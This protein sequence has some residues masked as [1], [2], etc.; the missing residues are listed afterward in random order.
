MNFGIV[1]NTEKDG[2]WPAVADL[3]ALLAREGHSA[4]VSESIAAGFAARGLPPPTAAARPAEGADVLLSFGGDGSLLRAAH[5]AGAT[6]LLGVNIGRLG[7]LTKAEVSDLPEV[8]AQL[9]DG[10]AGTE[11][12]LTLAVDMAGATPDVPAWALNDVVVDKSGTT[13]MIQ[14]ETHIDGRFLNTYW[15]DGLIAATPTGS[16]AYSLSVGG[17][18][19]SPRTDALVL[20]PIAPHTLTARPIVLPASAE[21]TMRVVTRGHPY[22]FAVDGVSALVETTEA[23]IRVRRGAHAVRLVTLPGRDYY[24]TVRDKL[25]WGQSGVF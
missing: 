15:A 8:V 17:P 9:A 7:F 3:L 13:S 22:A 21:L 11:E 18:I 1:G 25:K 10:R 12:R 16:T 20:T 14:I 6:P 24:A 4:C 19:L 5:E 23:V 2:L